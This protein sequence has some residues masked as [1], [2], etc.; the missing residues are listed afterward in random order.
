MDNNEVQMPEP[1]DKYIVM[2][3]NQMGAVTSFR[4]DYTNQF[5]E[6]ASTIEEPLLELGAAYGFV[7]HELLKKGAKVIANDMEP[8]HLS[9]LYNETPEQYRNNLTI[10]EGHCPEVLDL[11]K[12]SIGGCYV[13]RMLAYLSPEELQLA[14]KK[15]YA[16]LKPCA[17]LYILA[18]TPYRKIFEKIIPT[19]EK[20]VKD[21]EQWPGYFSDIKPLLE[22]MNE[23]A[24]SYISKSL[25]FYDTRVLS[26]ELTRAGFFV[27]EMKTYPREDFPKEVQ[28][29]GREGLA[30]VAQ[31]PYYPNT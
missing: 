29:D 23:I 25:H 26:R 13:A 31:K 8:K 30:V 20:R 10:L 22:P 3:L 21:F 1:A 18:S 5:I 24:A 27:Q 14:L 2:T 19:Y 12:D 9:I 7:T 16:C 28:R 4:D 15:I 11:P 6:A 17:K